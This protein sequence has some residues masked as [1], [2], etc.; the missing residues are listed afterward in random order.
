MR[1]SNRWRTL[2]GGLRA[3]TSA[4][5]SDLETATLVLRLQLAVNALTVHMRWGKEIGATAALIP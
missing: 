3:A 5:Q 1:Q 4:F 2:C